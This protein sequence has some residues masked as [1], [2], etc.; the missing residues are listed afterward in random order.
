MYCSYSKVNVLF[1]P[2]LPQ[3]VVKPPPPPPLPDDLDSK[4]H[5]KEAVE[6][7]CGEAKLIGVVSAF[8]QVN[9]RIILI[10][11]G[12][13]ILSLNCLSLLEQAT[14]GNLIIFAFKFHTLK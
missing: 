10:D 14:I 5:L 11:R 8:L 9:I 7:G 1:Q 4:V 12:F 13:V 2:P 6:A 3:P